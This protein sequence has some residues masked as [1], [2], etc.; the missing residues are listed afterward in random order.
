MIQFLDSSSFLSF[1][2][3]SQ[4]QQDVDPQP[5]LAAQQQNATS[6]QNLQY[7]EKPDWMPWYKWMEIVEEIQ[8]TRPVLA[9]T[10]P[11]YTGQ[12]LNSVHSSDDEQESEY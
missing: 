5:P 9:A 6:F 4:P 3:G 10:I 11:F 1:C 8:R 7:R 2:L 12:P